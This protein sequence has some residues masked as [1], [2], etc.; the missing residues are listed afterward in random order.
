LA[1]AKLFSRLEFDLRPLGLDRYF[2][3][4]YEVSVDR[5]QVARLVLHEGAEMRTV[6]ATEALEMK[7]VPY[8]GFAL[9]LHHQKKRLIPQTSRAGSNDDQT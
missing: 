6:P 8:D 1:Q 4:Y 2:R 3:T 5:D 7:L 9:Y